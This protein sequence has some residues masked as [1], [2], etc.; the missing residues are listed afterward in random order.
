MNNLLRSARNPVECAFGPLK[1][2]WAFLTKAIDLKLD[3]TPTLIYACF[4]LHDICELGNHYVD[5]DAVGR[6]MEFN[7]CQQNLQTNIEPSV[8]SRETVEGTQ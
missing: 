3:D 7:Q 8:Y 1:A 2:R 6:Q 5:Q 4:V